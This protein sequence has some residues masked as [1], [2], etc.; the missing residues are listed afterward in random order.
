MNKYLL[1]LIAIACFGEDINGIN[2]KS[3]KTDF[4]LIDNHL[5]A[6]AC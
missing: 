1:N 5:I 6:L 2:H 3:N 4:N